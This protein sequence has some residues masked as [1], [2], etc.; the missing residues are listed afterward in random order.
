MKKVAKIVLSG[1]ILYHL[2]AVVVGPNGGS[3]LGRTLYPYYSSYLNWLT[4][5]T[6]WQFFSPAPVTTW[7]E[8]EV[9]D[10][11]GESQ[12]SDGDGVPDLLRFP[13]AKR[14]QYLSKEGYNRRMAYGMFTTSDEVKFKDFLLPWLCQ[15]HTGATKLSVRITRQQ[16]VGIEKA[17]DLRGD[18]YDLNE[19]FP[20]PFR[21]YECERGVL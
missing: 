6:S 20:G 1:L 17:Q 3:L 15:V 10:E 21:E 16:I 11:D 4:I 18:V 7:V 12:D 9:L 5:N 13:P 14:P 19:V 8:Y 2:M